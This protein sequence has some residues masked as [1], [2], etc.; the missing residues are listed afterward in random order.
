MEHE[1]IKKYAWAAFAASAIIAAFALWN[2]AD[3]FSRSIQPSSFRSFSVTG[4]GKAISVPDIAAFTFS[5]V[6]QGDKNLA[7]I[8]QENTDKMNKA[9]AFVKAN[10]VA[11]KDIKTQSYSLQPRYQYSTCPRPGTV[12]PPPSIVGYEINQTVLVKVRD[13]TKIG[14]ILAGVV[15]NGAN[16]VSDFQF[17]IDDPTD[18]QNKARAEAIEKAKVKAEAVAAAGGFSVGRLLGIS[19]GGNYPQPMYSYAAKGF[20]GADMATAAPSI[21][22]GSQETTVN[23]TL[24]YEIK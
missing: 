15:N 11:D 7:P 1:K 20:G 18:A 4:E 2:Y 23:V 22:P 16:S 14:D 5:V 13:F 9:I 12:C 8:Q 6:T 17:K 10:G 19:E 24:Q 3:A 21:E